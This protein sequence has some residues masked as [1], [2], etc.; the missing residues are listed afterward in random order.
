[1]FSRFYQKW[2]SKLDP[3]MYKTYEE[4]ATAN[5]GEKVYM[6]FHLSSHIPIWETLGFST[7][8]L[9]S[10]L[11]LNYEASD[12]G[13]EYHLYLCPPANDYEHIEKWEGIDYNEPLVAVGR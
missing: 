9:K 4:A 11:F 2:D 3:R 7:D 5:P 8:L 10:I 6:L 13:G 12:D 1:M